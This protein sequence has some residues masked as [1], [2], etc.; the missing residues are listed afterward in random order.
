MSSNLRRSQR[1]H[2][3]SSQSSTSKRPARKPGESNLNFKHGNPKPK[4]TTKSPDRR[5]RRESHTSDDSNLSPTKKRSN[6][7]S[8]VVSHISE[9]SEHQGHF[10]YSIQNIPT[11]FAPQNISTPS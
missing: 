5:T 6:S 10:K 7:N 1:T 9:E 8:T 11:K 2:S 4:Q 3:S